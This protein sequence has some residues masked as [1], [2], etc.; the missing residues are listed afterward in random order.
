[1]W[2]RSSGGH[3]PLYADTPCVGNRRTGGT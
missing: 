3:E 1:L 2:A